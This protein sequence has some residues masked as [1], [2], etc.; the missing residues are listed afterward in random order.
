MWQRRPWAPAGESRGWPDLPLSLLPV[1]ALAALQRSAPLVWGERPTGTDL[2]LFVRYAEQYLEQG[3]VPVEFPLYQLGTTT[4]EYFPGGPLFFAWLAAFAGGAPVD[5][6]AWIALTGP[7]EAA[8]VYVLAWQ[9]YGRRD[10]ALLA[11]T[12]AAL[13]PSAV[14]MAGWGGYG[15]L[16][17]L[18]LMP[19]AYASWLALLATPGPRAAALTVLCTGAVGASHH[20]S[21]T[22]LLVTLA[23][24]AAVAFV[25]GQRGAPRAVLWASVGTLAWLPFVGRALSIGS[26]MGGASFFESAERFAPTREAALVTLG[27]PDATLLAAVLVPGLA[28][29]TFLAAVPFAGR[30]LVLSHV[31]LATVLSFGWVVG[32]HFHHWRA[33]FFFG[34]PA[35]LA[36]GGLLHVWPAPWRRLVA[37]SVVAAFAIASLQG[38]ARVERDYR[39]LSPALEDAARWLSARSAP[40]DVVLTSNRLGFQ[41]VRLLRRPLLV[42]VPSHDFFSASPQAVAL[43]RDAV[44]ILDSGDAVALARRDVRFVVVRRVGEDAPS[45]ARSRAALAAFPGR[46]VYQNA[47]VVVFE[48]AR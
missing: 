38:A 45:P 28:A 34:L 31:G 14:E 6:V 9:L 13:M 2:G 29:L 43:A 27:T 35:A 8:G 30:V 22:W 39:V 48:V 41:L 1:L 25:A 24:S 17:G 3:R 47:E 33:L 32:L 12:A 23:I 15:N 7:I 11:A 4:W 42:A 19:A 16:L 44:A 5:A 21:G 37:G 10:A 26:V 20:L 46:V 36:A 18:A 40:D